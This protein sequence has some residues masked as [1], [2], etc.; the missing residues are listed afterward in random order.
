MTWGRTESLRSRKVG[1]WRARVRVGTRK[2]H[3][4]GCHIIY[5]SSAAEQAVSGCG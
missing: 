1:S 5:K 2:E 3:A 4:D